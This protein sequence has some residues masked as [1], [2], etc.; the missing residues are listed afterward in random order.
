MTTAPVLAF[1]M[2]GARDAIASGMLHI[3][4][5]VDAIE[6][7]TR[8]NPG[9]TF[10][11][12]K[13][14]IE[15][16]CRTILTDRSVS[17]TNDDDLPR[18][19]KTAVQH[20]PLLP[21]E[22]S[23]DPAARRSLQQTINGLSTALQGVCELR[24]SHGFA[25][26]G[27]GQARQ[28]M[29]GAQALLAAQTA[30]AIVGFLYRVH[31]QDRAPMER[32]L[33][34]DGQDAFNAYLDDSNEP[35]RILDLEFRPSEVLFNVDYEAYRNALASWEPEEEPAKDAADMAATEAPE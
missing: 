13:T 21:P 24:N 17:F 6:A 30:D 31:T 11:L 16:A 32:R 12:A 23:A 7:A 28:S 1:T 14:L 26:H 29:A 9:L 10:D 15:S 22:S 8:D 35:V 2:L 34:F 20:L 19:F 27:A 4:Q 5:Q 33:E 25:S 3:E 18:L